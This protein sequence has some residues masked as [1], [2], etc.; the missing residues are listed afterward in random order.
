[1]TKRIPLIR[2][3]SW[4]FSKTQIFAVALIVFGALQANMEI[5]SPFLDEKNIGW[6]TSVIGIITYILRGFT[7]KS[8]TEKILNHRRENTGIVDNPDDE[9]EDSNDSRL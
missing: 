8:M 4:T 9:E 3:P 6:L 5:F 1:M 2:R 7:T